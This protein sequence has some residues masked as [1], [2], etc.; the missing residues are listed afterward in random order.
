MPQ[1]FLRNG[2]WLTM[3]QIKEMNAPVEKG[4]KVKS[5]KEEMSEP[6]EKKKEDV[7]EQK[8]DKKIKISSPKN[9][10]DENIYLEWKSEWA[11]LYQEN[12][13]LM[14]KQKANQTKIDNLVK[15]MNEFLNKKKPNNGIDILDSSKSNIKSLHKVDVSLNKLEDDTDNDDSEDEATDDSDDSDD[16][17]TPAEPLKKNIIK[18][19]ANKKPNKKDF[20]SSDSE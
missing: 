5:K 11:I 20:D 3:E 14:E 4:V 19:N 15:K 16:D 8:L 7:I 18:F 13:I 10:D 9:S 12:S 17:A 2:R 6:V 1:K